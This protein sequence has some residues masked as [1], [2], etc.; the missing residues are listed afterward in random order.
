[1]GVDFRRY[2][3]IGACNPHLAQ[4]AFGIELGINFEG[5]TPRPLERVLITLGDDGE[6]VVDK[7]IRYRYEL[8]QWSDPH[9]FVK[10]GGA[11]S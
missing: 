5:P 2:A 9:A 6:L 3:I 8:G 4:R 11:P 1:L 7:A 10:Y